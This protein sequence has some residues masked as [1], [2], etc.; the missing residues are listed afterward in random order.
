MVP[1]ASAV[2]T[3]AALFSDPAPLTL[4]TSAYAY[5]QARDFGIISE[6]LALQKNFYFHEKFRI[7]FRAD[8]LDLFN[9]HY[10]GG[11]V[12]NPTSPLFG[13]VTSVGNKDNTETSRTIQFGL[14][15]D[16]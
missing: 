1:I 10:L 11:I 12:T 16:F 13:Q 9:R 2:A 15:L 6:D 14:R 7:Q 8:F 4:G 5:T 3:L